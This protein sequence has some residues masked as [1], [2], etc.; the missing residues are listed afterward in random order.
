MKEDKEKNKFWNL[1]G[2]YKI[3]MIRGYVVLWNRNAMILKGKTCFRSYLEVSLWRFFTMRNI[4]V[5]GKKIRVVTAG[6][7]RCSDIAS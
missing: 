4:H 7:R 2:R 3:K 6:K 5:L 1:F